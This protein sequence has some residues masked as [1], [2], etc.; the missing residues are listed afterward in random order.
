MYGKIYTGAISGIDSLIATVEV[1]VSTGMPTFEMVGLLNHEVRE[2][3]ERVKVALKNTGIEIPP[4]RI[5]VSISPADMRKEGAA[6]DL[7]V[8]VGMLVS[9]GH[10]LAER[11]QDTL[12]VGELGLDGTVKSVK[13]ILPI[14]R[15]AKQEG[16]KRCIVPLENAKEGAIIKDIQ[17]IGVRSLQ[18]TI[19]YLILQEKDKASFLVPAEYDNDTDTGEDSY[20]VDFADING[21]ETVKR[22]MEVAAAGFHHILMIGPPGAGKTMMAKRLPTILPD[23]TME[24]SLEVSTIYSVAGQLDTQ[25]ALITRRPFLS[26]HHTISEQALAGGGR[27]P[28]PGVISLAH[29]GSGLWMNCRNFEGEHLKFCGSHWKIK[30]YI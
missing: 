7:P 12:I 24:E 1:D 23:L 18:E 9:L 22:A 28:K 21:Q 8:A 25:K 6:Y 26:P 19:D 17:V 30:R 5:T 27:I 14:V 2:A 29:R 13:G 15:K 3:K 16:H 20:D 11:I 10:L 4:K